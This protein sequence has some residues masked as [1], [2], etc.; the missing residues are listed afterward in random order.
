MNILYLV[1]PC[2]NDYQAQGRY[3]YPAFISLMTICGFGIAWLLQRI[4]SNKSGASLWFCCAVVCWRFRHMF[5]RISICHPPDR[6]N[7]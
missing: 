3:F 7:R 1:I 4:N 5:F 6:R 2:Y